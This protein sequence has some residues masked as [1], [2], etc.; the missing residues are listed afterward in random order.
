MENKSCIKCNK[1]FTRK[2]GRSL[3]NWNKQKFCSDECRKSSPKRKGVPTS[4]ETK[5]KLSQ[6]LKGKPTHPWSNESREKA[7]LAKLGKKHSEKHRLNQIK[8][9]KRGEERYNWKG[10]VSKLDKIIRNMYEYIQWRTRVFE[11]DRWTCQ[12]CGVRGVYVTAHHIKSFALILRENYIKNQE[13]ARIC[14][15]LWDTKNGVTLCEDC[16]KL[17]DNYKGRGIIKKLT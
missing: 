17:T 6:I 1:D 2:E 15:E 10:G 13:Q 8:N 5:K 7:R 14:E 12:T 16:H 3:S 9:A 11:R 4:E